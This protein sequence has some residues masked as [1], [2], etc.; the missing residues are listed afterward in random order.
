MEN[1]MGVSMISHGKPLEKHLRNSH[2][3]QL[4]LLISARHPPATRRGRGDPSGARDRPGVPRWEH[5]DGNEINF[6][7]EK[8]EKGI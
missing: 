1:S 8:V 2:L 3:S 7:W 4:S 6:Y 5:F